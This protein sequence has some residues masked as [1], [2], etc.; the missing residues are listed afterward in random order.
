MGKGY[1]AYDPMLRR[2]V[3]LKFIRGDDPEMTRRFIQEAQA[4]ARVDHPNICRVYEVGEVEEKLYIAMQLVE[5]H[6]LA[7]AKSTMSLKQKVIL[8]RDVAE[9]VQATHNIGQS[10]R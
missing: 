9:A 1:K 8:M 6:N 10:H 2:Y 7:R 4:Q 5:G 3:A